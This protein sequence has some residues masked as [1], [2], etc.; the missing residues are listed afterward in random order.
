M[1][2]GLNV[3]AY[4]VSVSFTDPFDTPDWVD[5]TRFV[6]S[7][8]T[9]RGRQHELQRCVAGSCSLKITN[10]DGRFST[11][12][13]TGPYVNLLSGVDSY[14]VDLAPSATPGTWTATGGA[15]AAVVASQGFDSLNALALTA[16]GTGSMV[17]QTA[18][19]TSGYAVTAGTT[20]GFMASFKTAVTSRSCTVGVTWYTAA[21]A[22]ISTTTGTAVADLTTGYTKATLT[23]TA[24]GTAAFAAIVATVT[25]PVVLNEVHYITRAMISTADRYGY[26]SP[27]WAPGGRGLVPARPVRVVATWS[28]TQY[29]VYYGYIDS[30]VPAYGSV[31]SDQVITCT[32]G[33]NLLALAYLTTSG[34]LAQVLADGAAAYWGFG[35]PV[36]STQAADSVG[37]DPMFATG[38]MG[39]PIFGQAGLL[40]GDNSTCASITTANLSSNLAYV[41]T[42]GL[43]VET[44]VE[45]TTQATGPT[46]L[47][48]N[49]AHLYAVTFFWNGTAQVAQVVVAG[50][51]TI[52]TSQVL[53][54]GLPHHVALSISSGGAYAFYVDGVSLSSGAATAPG[55]GD[56]EVL[57]DGSISGQ[58]FNVA[59]TAITPSVLTAAQVA[60]HAALSKTG[61]IQQQS[62]QRIAAVCTAMG[63]PSSSQNIATGI[64]AVQAPTSTLATTQALSYI[65]TVEN[66]EQGLFFVDES[67]LFTFYN[68]HY[69]LQSTNA[70]TSQGIFA[71][72]NNGAHFHY[73]SGSL[74][75]GDDAL[76][77]W[78]DAPV[79]AV[80]NA[81]IGV[82]GDTQDAPNVDSQRWYRRRSLQG[83]ASMLQ[84]TDTEALSLSQ[85]LVTHYAK[86][87]ARVR[88]MQVDSTG[89]NPSNIPQML[90]RKLLDRITVQWQPL[91][92]TATPFAQDSLVESIAHTFAPDKWSTTW[93]LSVAETQ[94]YF[95]LNDPVLG[96]LGTSATVAGNRLG[97]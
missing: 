24:P 91:D 54:D 75:P 11:F 89:T 8:T 83:Y 87:L 92:G 64:S 97:Y 66:T 43:T 15:T 33:M 3:P 31:A 34:Y 48:L 7:G 35:D 2:A 63:V 85:W 4:A 12:N 93:G 60:V 49:G 25:T 26:V 41:G 18:T 19:G 1:T 96:V 61:F 53:N 40:F 28:A 65:Q 10:Q 95:T 73:V 37:N 45:T 76:D 32:D 70:M 80:A 47:T 62:G 94:S 51:G 78:N 88:E 82:T 46:F 69:V 9:K 44:V 72:D 39:Y 22:S 23:A 68:R 27:G 38:A 30:W 14:F 81:T 84:T 58:S 56:Y 16:T 36:G 55:A 6:R 17:A 13:T 79:S 50:A 57:I 71:S 74:I 90:G 77:L 86:P 59:G 52:T 5:I 20:Y 21:G 29:P 42:N 67:G